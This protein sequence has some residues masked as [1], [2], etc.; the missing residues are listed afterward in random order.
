MTFCWEPGGV[1]RPPRGRGRSSGSCWAG[2][3]VAAMRRP[4][5]GPHDLHMSYVRGIS[6]PETPRVSP[7]DGVQRDPPSAQP[8]R[9]SADG[10]S[11][12]RSAAPRRLR[13]GG[14]ARRGAGLVPL[15]PGPSVGPSVK[16]GQECKCLSSLWS[17]AMA[18]CSWTPAT[19]CLRG[20]PARPCPLVSVALSPHR[21]LSFL[22]H[23]KQPDRAVQQ[24][25][26]PATC[27]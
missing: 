1:G 7:P 10:A 3:R 2:L 5:F 15:R 21:G 16:R 27:Q 9:R 14:P 6:P 8:S 17:R 24:L 4:P 22:L 25:S 19:C 11:S 12:V 20:A 23:K 26:L 18:T 13:A